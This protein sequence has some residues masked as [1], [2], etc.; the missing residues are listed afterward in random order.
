MMDRRPKNDR[1]NTDESMQTTIDIDTGG[2]FTDGV[3]RRGDEIERVKT[4]TTPHDLTVCFSEIIERGAETFEED[5]RE[6]LATVD[7]VR[8]STTLGTNAIIEREGA[9]IGVISTDDQ[10]ALLDRSNGLVTDIL[11]QGS[12]RTVREGADQEQVVQRYNELAEE[13]VESITVGMSSS[14]REQ[15]VRE[16]VLSDQPRHLLGSVPL[17]LSYDV[18][19]DPD[20]Y[21]RLTTTLI[22]SYLHPKLGQFLYKAE[23]YLRDNGYDSPLLVFCNDG[24]SSRVAKTMAIRTYNSGPS[25]GIQGVSEVADAYDVSNAVA[26]DIG[27]TSADVA[28]VRDGEIAR[29][30]FGTIEDVRLSFP[31]RKLYPTGGGGGTIA[32]VEDG[33]LSLG[34]E[35]AGARPGPACYGL[36]GQDATVTDADVVS[37]VIDPDLFAGDDISLDADRAEAVISDELADPIG[38][39]PAEAAFRVRDTLERQVGEFI[40]E[41]LSDNGIVPEESML[42]AYGGAGP[43][44]VCGIAE[45]AGIERIVVPGLPSVFSAYSVGFSNVVHDYHVRVDSEADLSDVDAEVDRIRSRANRDMDGEGFD[46][47]DVEFTWRLRGIDGNGASDLGTVDPEDAR[48]RMHDRL[49]EYDQLDLELTA[50]ANL[51][52]HEFATVEEEVDLEPVADPE[53]RWR[54][55]GEE[56]AVSTPVY[57]FRDVSG[58][59]SGT[60]PAVLRAEATTYAI[61]PAWSFERNEHGHTE[62]TTEDT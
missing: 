18:T 58:R 29:D 24:T 45:H 46:P 2:T 6:F 25:A 19:D 57:D 20:E 14:E 15:S 22:D 32:S 31:M 49:P 50:R 54:D 21:R 60:G 34:P 5:L 27:G 9:D 47:S 61:P 52:T 17:H 26:L 33:E 28:I 53:I 12:M 40:A 38:V 35:S 48:E 42:V 59:V 3:V 44:H 43:T 41:T 1:G 62:L 37:G 10:L 51:P 39:S 23:D 11:E 8:Y 16:V 55:D 4:S 7:C 30:E 56:T 36:G 13:L